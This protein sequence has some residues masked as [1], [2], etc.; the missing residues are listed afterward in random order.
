MKL[1]PSER[2]ELGSILPLD[3]SITNKMYINVNTKELV[4][5]H[6]FQLDTL[7]GGFVPILTY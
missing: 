2:I 5:T 4:F 1:M 3:V 7:S 6:A